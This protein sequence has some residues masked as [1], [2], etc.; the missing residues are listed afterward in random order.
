MH[1]QY[2]YDENNSP[3]LGK[4]YYCA[5]FQID[6]YIKELE[7]MIREF[8]LGDCVEMDDDYIRAKA[9]IKGAKDV[10]DS[11]KARQLVNI[12]KF[13]QEDL[14]RQPYRRIMDKRGVTR[15]RDKKGRYAK[16]P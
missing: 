1:R 5:D 10:L 13:E 11:L 2:R 14:A 7:E 6:D 12:W 8:E 15:W 9:W 16:T 3:T 4:F